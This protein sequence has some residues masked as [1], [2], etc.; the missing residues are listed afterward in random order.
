MS[1]GDG[2]VKRLSSID[3]AIKRH[4]DQ[5]KQLRKQREDIKKSFST[6]ME[7]NNQEE[8]A[9]YKLEKIKPK[10]K[11]KSKPKKEKKEDALRLFTQIGVSDPEELYEQFLI[12]QQ[13]GR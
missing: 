11:K 9:G 2:Y 4:N 5:L 12:T 6:W 8:Y 1:S 10:Q 13:A 7:R 3:A